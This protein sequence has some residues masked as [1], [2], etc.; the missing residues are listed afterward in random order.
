MFIAV[1][2]S[3]GADK[4][5]RRFVLDEIIP[6]WINPDGDVVQLEIGYVPGW[7]NSIIASGNLSQLGANSDGEFEVTRIV[8]ERDGLDGYG[9]GLH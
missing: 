5:N 6:T 8:S 7:A 2:R 9:L 4:G 1:Y 3:L